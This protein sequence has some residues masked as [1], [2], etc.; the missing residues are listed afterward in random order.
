MPAKKK[1]SFES[2]LNALDAL[3]TGMEQGDLPLE[4]TLVR[5]EQGMNM[6]KELE[7]ELAMAQQR[8]T[9]LRQQPDGTER[10]ELLEG[11]LLYTSDAADE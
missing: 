6:L 5:Y 8:L 3:I 11:C 2:Q 1:Q 9:V 4:E 7:N 10:E